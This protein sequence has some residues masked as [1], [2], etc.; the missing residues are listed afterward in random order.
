MA[1]INSCEASLHISR[2]V[3]DLCRNLT[4]K[5]IDRVFNHIHAAC[6]LLC[7]NRTIADTDAWEEQFPEM[8]ILRL[9][10]NRIWKESL[11]RIYGVE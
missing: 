3:G 11:R 6:K 1:R 2:N 5:Q 9:L 8:E 10:S 4:Q 7:D